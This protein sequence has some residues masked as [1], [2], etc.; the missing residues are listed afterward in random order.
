MNKSLTHI[1]SR[2]HFFFLILPSPDYLKNEGLFSIDVASYNCSS[3]SLCVVYSWCFK[4]NC[5]VWT[6]VT[7][8]K[9]LLGQFMSWQRKVFH[10]TQKLHYG[11]SLQKGRAGN[12]LQYSFA[13]SDSEI[14]GSRSKIWLISLVWKGSLS[15]TLGPHWKRQ[16]GS[17]GLILNTMVYGVLK[18]IENIR[19]F[20]YKMIFS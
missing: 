16:H 19:S 20:I 18:K 10:I 8:W 1:K 6:K 13:S 2:C 7:E 3:I 11:L 12:R 15:K 5:M 4:T 14:S 17:F 9:S